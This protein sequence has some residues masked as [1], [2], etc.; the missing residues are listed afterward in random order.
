MDVS[1]CPALIKRGRCIPATRCADVEMVG[2]GQLGAG[3]GP[4][5]P[6]PRHQDRQEERGLALYRTH[7]A[8]Q[9]RLDCL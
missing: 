5:Q 9:T 6:R 1:L 3:R 4:A 7:T 2:G 8:V